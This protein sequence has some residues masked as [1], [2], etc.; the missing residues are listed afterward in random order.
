MTK[1]VY[2]FL[3]CVTSVGGVG[4]VSDH[5]S[6]STGNDFTLLW[7]YEYAGQ[8]EGLSLVQLK[9][10]IIRSNHIVI[11]PD[12]LLTCLNPKNGKVSWQDSLPDNAWVSNKA[13]LYDSINIYTKIHKQNKIQARSISTGSLIWEQINPYGGFFDFVNDAIDE[14]SIYLTGDDPTVYIYTKEGQYQEQVKLEH[15][16][17]SLL[18]NNDNLY[19]SQAWRPE[20]SEYSA[21]SIIAYDTE[22]V[23]KLWEYQ[24]DKGGFYD[25]PIII[26]NDILFGGTTEGPGLFI[27]LDKYTGEPLWQK[28][29]VTWKFVMSDSGDTIFINN[30]LELVTLDSNTGKELWRTDFGVGDATDNIAY[31]NGYLYH[32]HGTALYILDAATGEIVHK[33]VAPPDGSFFVNVAAANGRVFAMSNYHLYA[34]DAWK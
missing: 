11:S 2:Y 10:E 16:G 5:N 30:S 8:P 14:T 24:T 33:E 15:K 31:L 26:Q 18:R 13:L 27:A 29:L 25:A 9:P 22:K 19:I 32:S 3:I 4:C 17:R 7:E 34:Y 6:N 12:R 23:Q 21:G 20:N 1:I 28:E